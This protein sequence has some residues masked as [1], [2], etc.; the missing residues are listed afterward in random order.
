MEKL[1]EF[2]RGRIVGLA[3]IVIQA[4]VVAVTLAIRPGRY[5][6]RL[7]HAFKALSLRSRVRIT[8][9]I[10][11]QERRYSFVLGNMRHGRQI[12]VLLRVVSEF[13]A[14][15]KGEHLSAVER[16]PVLCRHDD[17]GNVVGIAVHW[18][19]ALEDIK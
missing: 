11:D 6:R 3:K 15:T 19:T 12:N 2:L 14:M 16:L 4:A 10:Q 17:F 18:Y 9:K 1:I 8:G 5:L 7:Q 13:L